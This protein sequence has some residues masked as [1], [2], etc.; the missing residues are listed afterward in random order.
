[1]SST[2][3]Q[4]QSDE[5]ELGSPDGSEAELDGGQPDGSVEA[6]GN[7]LTLEEINKTLGKDFKDK[8]TALKAL[9]DTN[10]YV[11][12]LNNEL[13]Q[14]KKQSAANPQDNTLADKVANLEKTLAQKDFYTANPQYNTKEIKKIL[15]D[16]PINAIADEDMK[17][18]ADAIVAQNEAV[19]SKSVLHSNPRLGKVTDKFTQAQELRKAGNETAGRQAVTEAVIDAYE[20]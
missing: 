1:M 2:T 4:P 19:K 7:G 11:G 17:R 15:G 8:E 10:S 14:L 20:L 5:L 9:A 13:S 3:E 6:S 18:A 16:N 12:K